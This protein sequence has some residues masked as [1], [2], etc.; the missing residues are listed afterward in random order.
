MRDVINIKEWFDRQCIVCHGLRDCCYHFRSTA[1]I[2]AIL[3]AVN[4]EVVL[5]P[6]TQF[7]QLVELI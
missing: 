7:K 1:P 2:E 3:P 4:I 6:W 5:L